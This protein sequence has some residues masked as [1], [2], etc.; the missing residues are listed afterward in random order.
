MLI[1]YALVIFGALLMLTFFNKTNI[2][3]A[4]NPLVV[5]INFSSPVTQTPST[6]EVLSQCRNFEATLRNNNI[7]DRENPQRKSNSNAMGNTDAVIKNLDSLL[8]KPHGIKS[9]E[10]ATN[11]RGKDRL[12]ILYSIYQSDEELLTSDFS[13]ISTKELN[14]LKLALI[15][16]LNDFDRSV[17]QNCGANF[18][19]E[20]FTTNK[21]QPCQ[22]VIKQT[23]KLI[24]SAQT[25]SGLFASIAIGADLL[26]QMGVVDKNSTHGITVADVF[27]NQIPIKIQNE[28]SQSSSVNTQNNAGFA[29]QL[30]QAKNC[31]IRKLENYL[32]QRARF[33]GVEISPDE[34]TISKT[35]TPINRGFFY[36]HRLQGARIQITVSL[37][38]QLE[39][40][41]LITGQPIDNP[42][43]FASLLRDMMNANHECQ[44]S[45]GRYIDG[46]G[47][48]EKC[49]N[50]ARMEIGKIYTQKIQCGGGKNPSFHQLL[51]LTDPKPVRLTMLSIGSIQ[52]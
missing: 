11:N 2:Q 20:L 16:L 1:I 51:D 32:S 3:Y 34:K 14:H 22:E 31:L 13:H 37:L 15:D 18:H 52:G 47:E 23:Q 6:N 39:N 26:A 25:L 27:L 40:M 46:K 36:N 21:L 24:A 38:T 28:L 10:N 33:D 42:L 48:L 35:Y 4:I 41:Q 7:I 43:T 8:E 45:Y 5:T 29:F 44:S 12:E 17:L 30:S 49:L 50:E 9:H 19:K